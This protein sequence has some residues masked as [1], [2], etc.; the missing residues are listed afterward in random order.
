MKIEI[1]KL[2]LVVENY[3]IIDEIEKKNDRI[4]QEFLNTVLVTGEELTK[5]PKNEE[6]L[7]SK[8][9]INSDNIE[10]LNTWKYLL[11]NP[12]DRFFIG[13]KSLIEIDFQ[14]SLEVWEEVKLVDVSKTQYVIELTFKSRRIQLRDQKIK[15]N[16]FRFVYSTFSKKVTCK[17]LTD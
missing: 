11:K 6:L 2:D 13:E 7:K 9:F 15:K 17:R 16:K 4:L 12:K 3:Q 1:E 8:I 14:D 10:I 5:N